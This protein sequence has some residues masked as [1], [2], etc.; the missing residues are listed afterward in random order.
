MNE[1]Q[2]AE[3][4]RLLSRTLADL[5]TIIEGSTTTT[6]ALTGAEPASTEA[7]PYRA[8]R[9]N[10][11][12]RDG[13]LKMWARPRAEKDAALRTVLAAIVGNGGVLSNREF[14]AVA[15]SVGY[16]PRGLASFHTGK[17]N[18][19]VSDGDSV[20]LTDNGYRRYQGLLNNAA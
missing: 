3:C 14:H 6:S 15:R 13:S 2:Q 20:K 12:R 8:G 5:A 7:T 18:L 4:L 16:D 19:V 10:P 9:N 1:V 11:R 17:T